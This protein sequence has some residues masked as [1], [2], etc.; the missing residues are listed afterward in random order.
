[1]SGSH[2]H[3]QEVDI[4]KDMVDK[5]ATLDEIHAVFPARSLNAIRLKVE[6]LGLILKHTVANIDR[7]AYEK[8][9]KSRDID[10]KDFKKHMKAV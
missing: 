5:C 1:M 2:W 10:M 8:F 7:S 3:Q 4:L 9:L 6:A